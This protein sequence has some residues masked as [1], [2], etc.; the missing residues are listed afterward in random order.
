M[1]YKSPLPK[2]SYPLHEFLTGV[3]NTKAW[4]NQGIVTV[5]YGFGLKFNAEL[6]A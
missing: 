2:Y 5:S 3:I 4:E 1:E 6:S